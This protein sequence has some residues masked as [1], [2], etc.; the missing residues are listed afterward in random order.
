MGRIFSYFFQ[1]IRWMSGSSADQYENQNG[2]HTKKLI[3][4]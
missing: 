2:G 1:P 4:I 3:V